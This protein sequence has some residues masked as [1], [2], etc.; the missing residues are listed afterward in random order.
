MNGPHVYLKTP[1]PQNGCMG[2]VRFYNME[3]DSPYIPTRGVVCDKCKHQFTLVEWSLIQKD[4]FTALLREHHF[5][6]AEIEILWRA[7]PHNEF[8]IFLSFDENEIKKDIVQNTERY[9]QYCATRNNPQ[10]IPDANI[11]Y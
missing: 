11:P 7:L 2:R 3:S 8:G 9:K 6:E 1:C 4:I 5:S 10:E